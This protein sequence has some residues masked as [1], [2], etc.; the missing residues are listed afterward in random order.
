MGNNRASLYGMSTG[1]NGGDSYTGPLDLVPGAVVAYGVRALSAA[2]L[3]ESIFRLRRDSD[4]AELDFEADAVT[5]EAPVATINTWL[6]AGDGFLVTFYDQSGNGHDL[7]RSSAAFQPAFV[8]S[9]VGGK[10]GFTETREANAEFDAVSIPFPNGAYSGLSVCTFG[11]D[12]VGS[13]FHF[14]QSDPSASWDADFDQAADQF[15]LATD[16]T[17]SAGGIVSTAIQAQSAVDFGFQFGTRTLYVNGVA[18]GI[19]GSL[20]VDGAVGAFTADIFNNLMGGGFCEALIYNTLVSPA[21][22]EPGRTNQ[23]TEYTLS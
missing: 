14:E 11:R 5:G 12:T 23:M 22:R 10:C 13:F 17:N 21:T 6:G 15:L 1:S 9:L 3:G 20:D 2:W 16:G 4:D 18:L 7:T 19:D 8:A